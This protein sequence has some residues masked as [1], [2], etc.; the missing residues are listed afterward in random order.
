MVTKVLSTELIGGL[1]FPVDREGDQFRHRRNLLIATNRNRK[2]PEA[3]AQKNGEA[4][5]RAGCYFEVV[6][7][8]NVYRIFQNRFRPRRMARIVKKACITEKTTVIDVGGSQLIWEY[9]PVR[10]DLTLVNIAS[11]PRRRP[12]REVL[13]DGC[14]LPFG[15]R[16][17]DLAFSNSVIEHVPDHEA[18][19]REVVRVG[20]SYYVQT[21]NKWFPIEPHF[22]APF[23]HF[24]PSQWRRKLVRRCTVW[25]LT[26]KPSKTECDYVVSSTRLLTIRDMKRLFPDAMFEFEK[27]LGVTKSI[28]AIGGEAARTTIQDF[29]SA[30][31]DREAPV[32]SD[33]VVDSELNQAV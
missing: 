7:V 5:D 14:R 6:N 4:S 20:R 8:D 1:T 31:A 15:D 33:M 21:P 12:V 24:L 29:P 30:S 18:F 28:I 10:P 3:E 11:M 17:F 19:A 16:T 32:V 22:M 2:N 26:A 13:G 9:V 27:F 23:I 25:G